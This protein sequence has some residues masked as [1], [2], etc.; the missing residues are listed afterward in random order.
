MKFSAPEW[1]LLAPALAVAAALWPRLGFRRPLRLVCLLLVVLALA[2]PMIR[3]AA[4]GI[5]LWVVADRSASAAG[6]MARVL[7]EWESIIK[8]ARGANDELHFVDFA[9]TPTIR[10][11]GEITVHDVEETRTALALQFTL[12][13]LA[14]DRLAR[15]LLLTDGYATESLTSALPS[16][17]E[18]GVPVDF[19]LLTTPGTIDYRVES[20]EAPPR[21][22]PGE[23]F[24]V[25]A[26]IVGNQDAQFDAE[27]L[28]DGEK[29]GVRKVQVR[30]GEAR[31]RFSDRV[32]TPGAHRYAVR[33]IPLEDAH[34]EN[35]LAETWVEAVGRTRVLLV[36]A[37]AH[38]PVADILTAHGFEVDQVTDSDHLHAGSLSGV[39]LVILN[40][41]PSHRLADEFLHG[42]DFYVREQGGGLLMCGGKFSFGS[43][44]YFASKIDSLLPV[45]ME[46]KKEQRKLRVAMVV[47]MDRSG[48]MGVSVGN[49][50]T[51]MD[52]ADEG[53]ARTV[54][55]LS[56][57]DTIAVIAVDTEAH[58]FV[59]MSQVGPSRSDIEAQARRIHSE[60]GGIIVHKAMEAAWEELKN[61]DIGQRHVILFADASDSRQDLGDYKTPVRTMAD[62]GVTVSVIGMGSAT[63]CD[64]DILRDVAALG[65]G[66]IMFGANVQDIP[67]LFAEDTVAVA[68]SAFIKE[69]T[70]LKGTAGWLEIAA[71]PLV[72]PEAVDGYNLSYLKEGATAA[73]VSTDE[74]AAP[75]AAFWQRGLGRTAAVS[76]PV[77]G[78]QSDTVR[79]WPQYADFVTTLARWLS[80]EDLPSG[81]GLQAKLSGSDLDLDFFYDGADWLRQVAT[82]S[83]KMML[84]SSR[85]DDSRELA[86]E[87]LAPG[88]FHARAPLH[89]GE[90]IR[91]AV[92]IGKVALPFGPILS[93][94]NV[95]WQ[96]RPEAVLELR[97][98]SAMTGGKERLDLS[99]SW[100][101]PPQQ[102]FTEVRPWLLVLLLA[103]VVADALLTRL[104][105]MLFPPLAMD[106]Y[107]A[108]KGGAS[109]EAGGK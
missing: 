5:D 22:Q 6:P 16:L 77:A 106:R 85:T 62:A 107:R 81:L 20:L 9:A 2:G 18:S 63:D 88:H 38:D 98:L 40:N 41:V 75:L 15:I 11:A 109:E 30:K 17:T 104:G 45:S 97:S 13:K 95:E 103:L 58:H 19:R 36:T 87:R 68:R 29:I 24:F 76:F 90:R 92:Q 69:S 86:W 10:D 49:N 28:R 50:L 47:A 7:P 55:L 37:Y 100:E 72:W 35:N 79:S 31:L 34:P 65:N 96:F 12:G 94:S 25:E 108:E 33:I 83:P 44:G 105:W 21:V 67:A 71:S 82:N 80:G 8:R 32:P 51:K 73:A 4:D 101:A 27:V 102:R 56:D 46:L 14:K 70:P 48:S 57:S 84:A 99:K 74:N 42:L 66:R 43:G 26:R 1:F 61:S 39:K 53:A 93:A 23:S 78:D 64:A 52:L 59:P 3:R 54:G 60:G 89:P 91:G